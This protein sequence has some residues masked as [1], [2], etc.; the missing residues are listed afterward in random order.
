[1]TG[2]E[3]AGSFRTLPPDG[4]PLRFAVV[5]CAKYNAGFFNTYRVVAARDDLHFVLHLGDYIYEAGQ[6][7]RGTQTPSA[8]I[9]RPFEPFDECLTHDDYMTR[10]AQY[11]RDPDL[12]ALHARHAVWQTIDDHEL[13]DNA[14]SGGSEDHDEDKDGPWAERLDG[15]L[16]AWEY[17][18]PSAR[19]PEPRRAA[20]ADVL[21][22]RPG[23]VRAARD[24]DAPRRPGHTARAAQRARRGPAPLGRGG[25]AHVAVH[26]DLR[27]L[28]VDAV[29]HPSRRD[30][31]RRRGRAAGPQA[32]APDRGGAVPR[33]LGQL[34]GRA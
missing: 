8:D 23:P 20:R 32:A 34:P 5:S 19:P 13:A 27:G 29:E 11:R 33:P 7:P 25:A 16:R 18:T 2:S 21:G 9:G 1:M 22:R 15:A 12:L 30:A 24:P 6:V 26:V 10:Y 28:P 4:V 17:W 14:W 31:R 3:V